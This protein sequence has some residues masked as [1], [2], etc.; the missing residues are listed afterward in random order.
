VDHIELVK[1]VFQP[2]SIM[3]FHVECNVNCYIMKFNL[4]DD[5]C[6]RVVCAQLWALKDVKY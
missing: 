3:W 5:I 2:K 6:C 4:N 1:Q